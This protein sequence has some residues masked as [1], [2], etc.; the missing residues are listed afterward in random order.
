MSFIIFIKHVLYVFYWVN[1][2]YVPSSGVNWDTWTGFGC[3]QN[4]QKKNKQPMTMHIWF[5]NILKFD[6]FDSIYID[7]DQFLPQ[8][9]CFFTPWPRYEESKN[10]PDFLVVVLVTSTTHS[11]PFD[12][13]SRTNKRTHITN[14]LI[15]ICFK[16]HPTPSLLRLQTTL[17]LFVYYIWV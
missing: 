7:E 10:Y 8:S 2:N 11:H 1:C 15:L 12:G 4:G 5:F 9:F 14:D 6:L 3:S 13:H 17:F 16:T